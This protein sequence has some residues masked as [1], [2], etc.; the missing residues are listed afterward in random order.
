MQQ[1]AKDM[2]DTILLQVVICRDL[3]ID[4]ASQ[5]WDR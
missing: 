2:G 5:N 4:E 1:N 3:Q